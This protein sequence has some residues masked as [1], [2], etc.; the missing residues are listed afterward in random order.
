MHD[1][2]G[3]SKATRRWVAVAVDVF[4]HEFFVGDAFSRREAWLWLI[5]AAAW[6]DHRIDN[7]G[8]P[9]TLHRGEV[10]IARPHLAKQ[11]GWTEK[12]VR[13]FLDRL[14]AKGMI[15]D[16]GRS[17]GRFANVVSICNYE[18]YQKA[19]HGQGPVE[20]PHS[21]QPKKNIISSTSFE[22]AREGFEKFDLGWVGVAREPS[23]EARAAVCEALGIASATPIVEKYRTWEAAGRARNPDALFK[24]AAT[25]I[26]ARLSDVDR[27]RCGIITPVQPETAKR[28]AVSASAALLASLK[29]PGSRYRQ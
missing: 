23:P 20:G 3:G 10:V 16:R 11:W 27:L 1:E 2:H 8:K 22:A 15:S 13:C 6:K 19:L 5:A 29:D 28:R 21:T 7:N 24:R 18:K 9:T 25:K 26:F 14:S 12:A 17:K 4:T